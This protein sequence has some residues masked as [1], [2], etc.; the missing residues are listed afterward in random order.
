LKQSN[1]D[2]VSPAITT[3]PSVDLSKADGRVI[4]Y[5]LAPPSEFTPAQE[6]HPCAGRGGGWGLI[7]QH[8]S[9][10]VYPRAGMSPSRMRGRGADIPCHFDALFFLDYPYAAE[11]N[12]T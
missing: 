2:Q 11:Y 6:C 5:W 12:F 4:I 10:G 3:C 1:N 9:A 8:L 7:R